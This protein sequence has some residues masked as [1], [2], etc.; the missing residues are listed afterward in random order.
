ML[1][2]THRR[3]GMTLAA[4]RAVEAQPVRE[5]LSPRRRHA[6]R[7]ARKA[8]QVQ[9]ATAP[10]A[11]GGAHLLRH[12]L[13]STYQEFNELGIQQGRV[14]QSRG[15]SRPRN[16]REA[17]LPSGIA[18]FPRETPFA[19]SANSLGTPQISLQKSAKEHWA[20]TRTKIRGNLP[21]RS[22]SAPRRSLSG[23]F[24]LPEHTPQSAAAGHRPLVCIAD[25]W[26]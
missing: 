14:A 12:L 11:T 2:K 19:P 6:T 23:R 5:V 1:E 17:S 9:R 24:C 20:G 10:R 3:R 13:V 25:D 21:R 18:R 7:L 8:V 26:A 15:L 16:T 22:R 4:D